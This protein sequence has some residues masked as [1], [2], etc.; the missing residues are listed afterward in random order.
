[1]ESYNRVILRTK[2][3]ALAEILSTLNAQPMAIELNQS[4]EVT[5]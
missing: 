2:V 4:P 5:V 1:M 3:S